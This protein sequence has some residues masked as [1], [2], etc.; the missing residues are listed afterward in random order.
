ME[1]SF[2]LGTGR[3]GVTREIIP[4]A[5]LTE[6]RQQRAINRPEVPGNRGPAII[7]ALERGRCVYTLKSGVTKLSPK[8][9][10]I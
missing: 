5:M 3:P 8:I 2:V 10:K 6:V 4:R 7:A 9:G 1:A